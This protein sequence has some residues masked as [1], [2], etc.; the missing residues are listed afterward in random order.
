MTFV[1]K[2]AGERNWAAVAG[3]WGRRALAFKRGSLSY[4]TMSWDLPEERGFTS[5]GSGRIP[6]VVAQ[7]FGWWCV[8]AMAQEQQKDL[9]NNESK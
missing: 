8:C 7:S 2:G 6:F 9:G 1:M 5:A 3:Y 4:M